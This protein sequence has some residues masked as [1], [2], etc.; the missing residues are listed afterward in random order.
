MPGRVCGRC[1]C[2]SSGV[3]SAAHSSLPTGRWAAGSLAQELLES[4]GQVVGVELGHGRAAVAGRGPGPERGATGRGRPAGAP[5]SRRGLLLRAP[6]RVA[7]L[8]LLALR[9][10][11]ALAAPAPETGHARHTGDAATAGQALHHLLG[12]TEPLEQLVDLR[13]G[14]PRAAG[15]AGPAGA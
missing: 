7:G 4:L 5:G 10:L 9:L 13:D 14:H 8:G 3:S 1:R 11:L 15:D 12:L 6:G 2:R